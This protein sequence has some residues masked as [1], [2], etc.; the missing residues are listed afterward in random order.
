METGENVN[1][2]VQIRGKKRDI[3]QSNLG[4]EV[5]V[6][7]IVG[8]KETSLNFLRMKRF[9]TVFLRSRRIQS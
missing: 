3:G 1:N 2:K 4:K 7:E 6:L 5:V 9:S 8:L